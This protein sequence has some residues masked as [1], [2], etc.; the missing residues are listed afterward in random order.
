[1]R[2]TTDLQWS[3]SI[4]IW[5]QQGPVPFASIIYDRQSVELWIRRTQ[6]AVLPPCKRPMLQQRE[7]LVITCMTVGELLGAS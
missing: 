2:S 4:S 6:A 3:C 5:L 7:I 1:M